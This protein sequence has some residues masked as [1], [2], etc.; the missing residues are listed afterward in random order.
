MSTTRWVATALLAIAIS[1]PARGQTIHYAPF[2]TPQYSNGFESIPSNPWPA[3]VAYSEGG[4]DVEYVGAAS[5]YTGVYAGSGCCAW[6]PN[7]GGNGYTSFRLTGGG[8]FSAIQFNAGNGF[9]ST[10]A[11]LLYELMLGGVSVAS[12][13]AGPMNFGTLGQ[14]TYGF[15]GILMDEVRV[16]SNFNSTFDPLAYEALALDNVDIA[17]VPEPATVTLMLTGLAGIALARRR[18]RAV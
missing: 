4:I 8:A 9:G 17:A 13:N 10:S 2:F 15:D 6:Y 1:S 16:Q 18:S 3:N 12:G 7:G 11:N 5:I 14:L